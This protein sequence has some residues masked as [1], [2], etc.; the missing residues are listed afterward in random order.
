MCVVPTVIFVTVF[1][2]CIIT[3]GLIFTDMYSLIAVCA[4][5]SVLEI[6]KYAL[7]VVAVLGLLLLSATCIIAQ[8]KQHETPFLIPRRDGEDHVGSSDGRIH[9]EQGNSFQHLLMSMLDRIMVAANRD[10]ED[11]QYTLTSSSTSPPLLPVSGGD[12]GGDDALEIAN[13]GLMLSF[14]S[15]AVSLIVYV[16]SHYLPTCQSCMDGI[17]RIVCAPVALV[18]CDT[19]FLISVVQWVRV[20]VHRNW[21]RVLIFSLVSI[22]TIA[23]AIS[24]LL[25]SVLLFVT[26]KLITRFKVN[27]FGAA[28]KGSLILWLL[29]AFLLGWSVSR[30]LI[31]I[32][33]SGT[34][35]NRQL[36]EQRNMIG[37][38]LEDSPSS[39]SDNEHQEQQAQEEEEVEIAPIEQD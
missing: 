18:Q 39:G 16:R 37:S 3:Q 21:M 22:F 9:T 35:A 32:Y 25:S 24:I 7:L 17:R 15:T 8:Y 2:A 19:S 10:D 33:S 4:I 12:R 11:S 29:H 5:M 36:M 27:N 23:S 20:Q 28:L 30:K 31:K 26:A 34:I 38:F 14:I 13:Q 6:L 1:I